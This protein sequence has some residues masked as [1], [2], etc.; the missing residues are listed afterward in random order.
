[1][2]ASLVRIKGNV[3]KHKLKVFY[4]YFNILE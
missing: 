3:N 1:M 4:S 2:R